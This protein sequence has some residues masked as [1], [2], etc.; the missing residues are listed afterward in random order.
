MLNESHEMLV[1]RKD[2]IRI[3]DDCFPVGDVAGLDIYEGVH[4]RTQRK[5]YFTVSEISK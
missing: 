2:K 4:Q 3:L 5:I 1:K